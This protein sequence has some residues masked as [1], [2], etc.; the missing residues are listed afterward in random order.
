M[1]SVF[2]PSFIRSAPSVLPLYINPSAVS[3][4]NPLLPPVTPMGRYVDIVPDLHNCITTTVVLGE[5]YL[6]I[7]FGVGCRLE[8][9]RRSGSSREHN[10]ARRDCLQALSSPCAVVF[11]V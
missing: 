7:T 2:L 1:C 6:Q 11:M 4:R 9:A 8:D 5:I 10:N 3:Q